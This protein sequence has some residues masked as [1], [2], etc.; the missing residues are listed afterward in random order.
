MIFVV[1]F[2][3]CCHVE[4]AEPQ[5]GHA[6][7]IHLPALSANCLSGSSAPL[8]LT[9]TSSNSL[10][11]SRKYWRLQ[12]PLQKKW[13]L[14]WQPHYKLE[15]D[16]VD[17]GNSGRQPDQQPGSTRGASQ[18]V[19]SRLET[20]CVCVC[21]CTHTDFYCFLLPAAQHK[22]H[23]VLRLQ[24]LECERLFSLPQ[25]LFPQEKQ[26]AQTSVGTMEDHKTPVHV[27]IPHLC[28]NMFITKDGEF[29][30]ELIVWYLGD[31]TG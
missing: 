14:P 8:S 26:K 20:M 22:R 23:P 12:C 9:F 24:V 21:V 31:Y 10:R 5:T 7:Q 4:W 19:N 28:Q 3:S 29:T 2:G 30:I 11:V 6:R 16:D 25:Q 15:W 18:R 27:P 13:S 17:H 1:L